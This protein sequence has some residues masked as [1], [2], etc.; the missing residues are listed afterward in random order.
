MNLDKDRLY[1]NDIL[2]CCNKIE[3]YIE[4]VDRS[5]FLKNEQLQDAL[6]RNI[7]VMGDAIKKLNSD[8]KKKSIQIFRGKNLPE[9]VIKSF[10][11]ILK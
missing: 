4:G 6:L 8:I 1:L 5:A 7:T 10:I 3:K 9:C 11:N 2:E